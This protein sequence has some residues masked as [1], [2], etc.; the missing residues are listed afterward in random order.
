MWFPILQWPSAMREGIPILGPHIRIGK[1]LGTS[2]PPPNKPV[3][4]PH[5]NRPFCDLICSRRW[6]VY[7]K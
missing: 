4:T 3:L 5:P 6:C 2:L 7:G 1:G